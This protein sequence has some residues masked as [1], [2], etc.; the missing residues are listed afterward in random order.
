MNIPELSQDNSMLPNGLQSFSP[1][2]QTG[3]KTCVVW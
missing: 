3:A 1:E 2:H